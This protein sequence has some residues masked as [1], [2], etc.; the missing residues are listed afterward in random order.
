MNETFRTRMPV[1]SAWAV[2]VFEIV[3]LLLLVLPVRDGGVAAVLMIAAIALTTFGLAGVARPGAGNWLVAAVPAGILAAGMSYFTIVLV[4]YADGESGLGALAAVSALWLVFLV[5]GALML[6]GS[7]PKAWG[8]FAFGILAGVFGLVVLPAIGGYLASDV[9]GGDAI[10]GIA[11]LASPLV[12]SVALGSLWI[13]EL[14]SRA[15][16]SRVAA[17]RGAA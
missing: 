7:N 16:G 13:V 5:I 4:D 9:A 6:R 17:K 8:W 14:A 12:S 11:V 1:V 3:F 2:F 10:S 15:L